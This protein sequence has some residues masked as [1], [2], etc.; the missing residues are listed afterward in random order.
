MEIPT[1]VTRT[2]SSDQHSF[3]NKKD[4]TGMRLPF[5]KEES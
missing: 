3:H 4:W 5:S 1:K 2:D